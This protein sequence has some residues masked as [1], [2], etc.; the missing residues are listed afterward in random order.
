MK[1]KIFLFSFLIPLIFPLNIC[2]EKYLIV[3]DP[4]NVELT[5]GLGDTKDLSVTFGSVTELKNVNL[6]IVP[7][8]RPYVS[9][10]PSH[11][12]IIKANTP[13]NISLHFSVPLNTETRHYGGTIHLKVGSKTYPQTFK[14]NLNIVDVAKVVGPE[15][16][17]LS[18]ANGLVTVEIPAGA[19]LEDSLLTISPT[20]ENGIVGN[21]YVFGPSD[22]SFAYPVK[23]SFFYLENQVPQN[24][25]EED[26]FL[27]SVGEY[28]EIL[29]DIQIDPIN[30]KISGET[31]HFS[32]IGIG[33]YLTAIN[34]KDFDKIASDFRIPIGDA[35]RFPANPMCG[36]SPSP[37]DAGDDLTLLDISSSPITFNKSGASNNR[38]YVS[39]DFLE[40]YEY[41]IHPGEDWNDLRYG[42][43]DLRSPIHAIADGVVLYSNNEGTG[44]GNIIVIGHK[45]SSG[46]IIES[47]YAHMLYLSPCVQIG[48][49]NIVK[50][51]NK[52]DIIGLIGKSG[53]QEWAHLHFEI[54][55]E[56]CSYIRIDGEGNIKLPSL[57]GKRWNWPGRLPNAKEFINDNYYEPSWFIKNFSL[58]PQLRIIGSCNMPGY[59]RGIAVKGNYA[60]VASANDDMR[61]V[62]ISNPINPY[63]VATCDMPDSN[64]LYAEKITIS[65]NYAYV[66]AGWYDLQVVDITNPLSPRIVGSCGKVLQYGHFYEITIAGNYA[67][68]AASFAGVQVINI[69]SPT[70]PFVVG[71]CDTPGNA[72]GIAIAG[73]YAY[74]ADGMSGLQIIDISNPINPHV[75]GSCLTPDYADG[76]AIAGNYAYVADSQSGLQIIDISSPTNPYII[77]S[78]YIEAAIIKDLVLRGN[79]AYLA[80]MGNSRINIVDI[81]NPKNPILINTCFVPGG[82]SDIA[83]AGNY[84][85]VASFWGGVQ[86]LSLY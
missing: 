81:S 21:I 82:P 63:I 40:A 20:E 77:G 54:T 68:A 10:A 86:V 34:I 58:P 64:G 56:D 26:L 74:V 69:S 38:W 84:A 24:V 49:D 79:Y 70:N 66:A 32:N 48:E 41:G 18:T 59:P 83:L 2:T 42:D 27:G 44:F 22:F 78:C 39:V 25:K 85:Y 14:I 62:D 17:I 61:V 13:Y 15:G 7:E 65:G 28:L 29:N 52:G 5:L 76:I 12:E 73:N 67:Y 46:K 16:G 19:I 71:S 8:L 80:N 36:P 51:I 47:V 43:T 75:I 35:R 6:W 50:K 55:K 3:W 9:V 53:G 57:A 4:N 60:Y 1:K 30:N 31:L 37:E 45:L 33:A 72:D 11:F 23:V